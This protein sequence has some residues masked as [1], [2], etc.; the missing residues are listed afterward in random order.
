LRVDVVWGPAWGLSGS[1]GQ[2][3]NLTPTNRDP[4]ERVW[5][6]A[7]LQLGNNMGAWVSGSTPL[8]DKFLLYAP[9]RTW[10]DGGNDTPG[11]P[12]YQLPGALSSGNVPVL[13]AEIE[14]L[15]AQ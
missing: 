2:A 15:L 14:A 7:N 3:G 6:D 1:E 8:Y 12:S 4:R 5:F 13:I 9:G 10:G 11:A